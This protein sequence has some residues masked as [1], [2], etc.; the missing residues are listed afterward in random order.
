MKRSLLRPLGAALVC[1]LAACKSTPSYYSATENELGTD[2]DLLGDDKIFHDVVYDPEV[3]SLSFPGYVVGLEKSER[4]LVGARTEVAELFN[5]TGASGPGL[6]EIVEN[7]AKQKAHYISHVGRF[8]GAPYGAGNCLLYSL[9]AMQSPSSDPRH[10]SAGAVA[11]LCQPYLERHTPT[12]KYERSRVAVDMLKAS[13]AADVARK[14]PTHLIVMVMGWN[15]PQIEAIRN[16]NSMVSRLKLAAGSEPF[17]PIFVGVT[18]SSAWNQTVAD[19]LVKAASYMV[20]ASDA[21]EVGITWLGYLIDQLA[22]TMPDVPKVVVGHSFGARAA[23][24]AVCAG[25]QF[26]DAVQTRAQLRAKGAV[27]DLLV[28]LQP[29]VSI[30]RFYTKGG[31]EDIVYQGTCDSARRVVLTASAADGALALAPWADM[32]GK[33]EFHKATCNGDARKT[34]RPVTCVDALANGDLTPKPP[35]SAEFIYINASKLI[36]YQQPNTGGG[37]HSDIYRREMGKLVWR[38]VRTAG[39]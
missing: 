1:L 5:D 8:R 14:K 31:S 19:G 24:T 34:T 25:P 37:S 16:F 26:I 30:N 18:W 35:E 6:G 15:T 2:W 20:K 10:P 39:P 28:G 3:I 38:L 36:A 9:Y 27:V 12:S 7:A 11:D 29:A 33:I 21:D 4:K 23:A 13:I 32:A 22:I 17:E